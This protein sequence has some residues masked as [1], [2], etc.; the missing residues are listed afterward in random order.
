MFRIVFFAL[1]LI[2][3]VVA[4]SFSNA[5][6]SK[7]MSPLID[8]VSEIIRQKYILGDINNKYLTNSA[9]DG[10]LRGLDPYSGYFDADELQNFQNN[11]DGLFSGIG[12]EMIIDINSEC[13]VITNVFDNSPAMKAGLMQ[14]DIITH[15]DNM[16][17]VGKKQ[18]VVAGMLKGAK[19]TQVKLTIFRYH[20]NETFSVILKRDRVKTPSVVSKIYNNNIAIIEVKL[21]NKQTYND[22]V[23]QL[24]KI[25][26]EYHLKGIIIDLRNNPGG[27]LESAVDLANLF[28]HDGQLITTVKGRNDVKVFEYVARNTN[29]VLGNTKL[30]ILINK[31]SASASEILAGCLQDYGI[32]KLI[33]EQTFGKALVQEVFTLQNSPGA[34]KLTT[35]QYHTPK[36]KPINGIGITPDIV[37]Q[38]K[39]TNQYDAILQAGINYVAK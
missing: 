7:E 11:A 8:E 23:D 13:P 32:A 6:P 24:N 26:R 16:P 25:R 36:D 33:G 35:G 10:M 37:V 12:I 4:N 5:T 3:N 39:R 21:F 17:L 34:V 22:F 30:A 15:V 14:G 9:V 28:L 1:L 2:V 31:G 19:G 20:T 29:N 18:N 38:E 27:L